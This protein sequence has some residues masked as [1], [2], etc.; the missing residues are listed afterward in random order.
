MG[1]PASAKRRATEIYAIATWSIVGLAAVYAVLLRL[2]LA[3]GLPLWFDESWT[4][5]MSSAPDLQTFVRYIRFDSNAPLYY[6]LIWLWP[7]ESDLGLR[8]PNLVFLLASASIA[9]L[10]RP[11]AVRRDTALIWAALILLWQ[12]GIGL[13]ID[14]RYY[15]LLML[16]STAQ[17]IAF[18]KLLDEPTLRRACGWTGLATLAVMTHYYAAL[19]ALIQGLAYL[20]RHRMAAVRS[21][22]AL[23][24][25]LPGAAWGLY[26]LPLLLVYADPKV[27]WYSTLHLADVPHLLSWPVAI[28]WVTALCILILIMVFRTKDR[29][30]PSVMIAVAASLVALAGFIAI[31]FLRPSLVARYL[32]PV[33][34]ALLLGIASAARPAGYL[35]LAGLFFLTLDGAAHWT[36]RVGTARWFG[37]ERPA[38]YLPDAR[39]VTWILDLEKSP[40]SDTGRSLNEAMLRDAFKR[41]GRNIDAHYGGD[42]TAGDGLIW[43]YH[44]QDAPSVRAPAQWHCVSVHRG[45]FTTLICSRPGAARLQSPA[46]T[47]F[48]SGARASQG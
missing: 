32:I 45:D 11:P 18:I 34:P 42:P 21:W 7:F 44:D 29:I 33:V 1:H 15:A 47:K 35:P 28:N 25:I 10:W 6:A 5:V 22:P 36:E 31:G 40:R 3:W 12:P 41:N 27:A 46:A 9:V 39:R 23:L 30:A 13:F 17:S 19:L 14:A 48:T 20:W 38:R 16:I 24:L 26:H 37:L 4:A 8:I 2:Y 43:L